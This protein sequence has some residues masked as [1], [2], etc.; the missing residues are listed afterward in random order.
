MI[1]EIIKKS[2]PYLIIL[3]L[4]T[5]GCIFIKHNFIE[6]IYDID[7]L[8]NNTIINELH[9]DRLESLFKFITYFGSAPVLIGLALVIII[10]LRDKKIG[11][12]VGSNLLFIYLLS[13]LLKNIF[14]RPRPIFSFIDASGYSF[15][16]SHT[17]CAVAFF[18]LF[19][20]IV[21][22]NS[23][24][25]FLKTIYLMITILLLLFIG[26][27]RVYLGVHFLSD[28]IGAFV[29]GFVTLLMFSKILNTFLNYKKE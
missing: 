7:L 2:I 26:I 4:L 12:I 5:L 18:G 27:S 13:I 24:S 11:V 16:S 23:N 17:M 25:L 1:K 15:P 14:M 6:K 9:D 21:M 20:I 28:I 10:G 3:V 19:Y 29:F 22:R 8:I